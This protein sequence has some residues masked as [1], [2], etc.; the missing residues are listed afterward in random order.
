M[1]VHRWEREQRAVPMDNLTRLAEMYHRPLH[2]FLTLYEGETVDTAQ[3]IY[4]PV[5]RAPLSAQQAVERAVD[6]VL[7]EV[8]ALN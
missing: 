6:A 5:S 1:T 2:W 4:D 7:R 8:D 3:R